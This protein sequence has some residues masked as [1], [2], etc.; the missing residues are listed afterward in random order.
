M[1]ISYIRGRKIKKKNRH[2]CLH[3]IKKMQSENHPAFF[4]FQSGRNQLA[5][6]AS[7]IISSL[8]VM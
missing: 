1:D 7:L 3:G 6:A 8:A 2:A 4:N 5:A